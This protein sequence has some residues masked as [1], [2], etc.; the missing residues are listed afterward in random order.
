MTLLAGV[1]NRRVWSNLVLLAVFWL[2]YGVTQ[3]PVLLV[4]TA[5]NFW[6]LKHIADR[7]AGEPD[8]PA[9]N[10]PALPRD[11]APS[12][13]GFQW[14]VPLVVRLVG[15]VVGGQLIAIVLFGLGAG[16]M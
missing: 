16:P 13:R 15:L 10:E 9:I 6:M 12:T 2:V 4:L 1:T 7:Q 14:V 5:G 3:W 11:K 8:E